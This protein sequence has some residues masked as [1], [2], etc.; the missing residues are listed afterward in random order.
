MATLVTDS[1]QQAVKIGA[2]S[3]LY[4]GL[5]L[6]V[7]FGMNLIADLQQAVLFRS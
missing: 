6:V 1:E 5:V 7:C 4:V 3:W 2:V